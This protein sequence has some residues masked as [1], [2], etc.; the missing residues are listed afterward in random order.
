MRVLV[1][2]AALALSSFAV[3]G[4]LYK[5]QNR[6]VLPM[7]FRGA[8]TFCWEG[9]GTSQF[10]VGAVGWGTHECS[11]SSMGAGDR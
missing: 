8:E 11:R 10:G 2:I 3:S 6:Q 5:D 7:S 9:V 1:V 4:A